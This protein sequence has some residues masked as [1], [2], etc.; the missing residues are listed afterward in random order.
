MRGYG[1]G[2]IG[3]LVV[4]GIIIFWFSQ[5][6]IPIAKKGKETQD[7]ARQ[8]A[9]RD[10][11][12]RPAT[13]SITAEGNLKN[14]KMTALVVKTVDAGGAMEQ[15]YGL[16]AGDE[17]V[18]VAEQP[19]DLFNGDEALA[20]GQLLEAYKAGKPIIVKRG[21]ETVTLNAKKSPGGSLGIPLPQ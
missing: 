4:V 13:D 20:K 8:I 6:Q 5:T 18:Q 17:I 19:V 21:D 9:G 16:K 2:L 1:F 14:G 3:L 11:D 10:E 15:Q 12:G 7:V